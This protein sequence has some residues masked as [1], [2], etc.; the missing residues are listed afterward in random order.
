M[1]QLKVVWYQYDILFWSPVIFTQWSASKMYY[2][3]TIVNSH[4][5]LLHLLEQARKPS[6][7]HGI[8]PLRTESHPGHG[9]A[10]K[11]SRNTGRELKT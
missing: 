2:R 4:N 5:G 1:R 9:G 6:C 8:H 11:V 10:S 7:K 3:I